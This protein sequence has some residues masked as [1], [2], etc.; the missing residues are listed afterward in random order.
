MAEHQLHQ[1]PGQSRPRSFAGGKTHGLQDAIA[2]AQ[3]AFVAH[4]RH[5]LSTPLNAVVGYSEILLEE[6]LPEDAVFETRLEQV[7]ADGREML[8]QIQQIVS[9]AQADN[10]TKELVRRGYSEADI[11]KVWGGNFLRVL[12]A[13]EAARKP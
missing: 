10:V 6:A 9:D 12:A 8:Q 5:E 2:R 4:L 3:R 11:A 7:L 13:A 1:S